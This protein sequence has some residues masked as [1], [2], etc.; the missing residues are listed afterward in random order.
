M[1]L[2]WGKDFLR[3]FISSFDELVS[4]R[5]SILSDFNEVSDVRF[6]MLLLPDKSSTERL[7]HFFK[8]FISVSLLYEIISVL[9]FVRHSSEA[10]SVIWFSDI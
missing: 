7:R 6:F 2:H 9:R 1:I 8:G 3:V 10:M 5:F 4:V